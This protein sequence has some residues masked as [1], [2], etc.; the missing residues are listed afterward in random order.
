MK[1]KQQENPLGED[2]KKGKVPGKEFKREK[3]G[4]KKK[5]GKQDYHEFKTNDPAWYGKYPELMRNAGTIPFAHRNGDQLAW[6]VCGNSSNGILDPVIIYDVIMNPGISKDIMSGINVTSTAAWKMLHRRYRGVTSYEQADFGIIQFGIV[7]FFRNLAEAERIYGVCKYYSLNQ[8]QLPTNLMLALG[9][10]PESFTDLADFRLR[11]NRLI[12]SAKTLC[13]VRGYSL[14]DHS[15]FLFSHIFKDKDTDRAQV[16]AFRSPGYW[17]YDP[18]NV[19]GSSLVY[20]KNSTST[21]LRNATVNEYFLRKASDVLKDLEFQL[22]A[23]ITDT[24]VDKVCSDTLA[25]FGNKEEPAELVH[26]SEIPEEYVVTPIY[27]DTINRQMH[28]MT[29]FG[30]T[31]YRADKTPGYVGSTALYDYASRVP[32]AF[33]T[34]DLRIWQ[35]N[36]VIKFNITCSGNASNSTVTLSDGTIVKASDD[37]SDIG[38]FVAPLIDTDILSPDHEQVFEMTRLTHISVQQAETQG[39]TTYI[40]LEC[41]TCPSM[42]VIHGE[43]FGEYQVENYSYSATSGTGFD[44][45]IDLQELKLVSCTQANASAREAI[46][47]GRLDWAPILYESDYV[48]PIAD[49]DNFRGIDSATLA[50]INDIAILSEFKNPVVDMMLKAE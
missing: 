16:F 26:L 37:V 17:V 25:F 23:L 21:I 20:V 38:E 11:L 3:R 40:W 31:A 33:G 5:S 32:A 8:K 34:P 36:N 48:L 46:Y 7:D 28:N 30:C 4:N 19:N 1:P 2:P 27:S 41:V 50:P 6:N 35:E 14:L 10:D 24:D 45:V 22:K 49:L 39:S 29:I 42:L 12:L 18:T 13:L 43:A 47:F 44:H 9:F 15:Q